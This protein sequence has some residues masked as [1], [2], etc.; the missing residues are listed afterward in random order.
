M[1]PTSFPHLLQAF[2]QEWLGGQRN[3]SRHTVLSYRDTWRL[4]LRFVASRHARAVAQLTLTDLTEAE[5]LAFLR[6]CEDDRH[7]S[8][9]T[10]NCRLAALRSFFTYIADREP[11]AAVQCAEV[12]RIP[13]KR[14]P[15]PALC[16]LDADEVT[17]ILAQPDRYRRLPHVGGVHHDLCPGQGGRERPI[18]GEHRPQPGH[19]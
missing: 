5:V 7:T 13:T 17:A 8:I 16:Y 2:F 15:M 1:T 19:Q 9:G 6:H 12:L 18:R 4:F 14:G 3:L 11:T 10:R